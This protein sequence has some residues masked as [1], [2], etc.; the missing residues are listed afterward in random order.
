MTVLRESAAHSSR[1]GRTNY[2]RAFRA[3]AAKHPDALDPRTSLLVLG[4]ARSNYADLHL[5]V[6][7]GMVDDARHSYWLN[8]EA[9]RQ[10]G[11]G[12]S[13]AWEYG[14]VVPMTECRNLEQ[15]GDFVQALG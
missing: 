9:R 15:L 7:R 4:D 8:P 11:T 6:L 12:D 5:D 13:V 1:F 3:F 14:S 10:W 2:G